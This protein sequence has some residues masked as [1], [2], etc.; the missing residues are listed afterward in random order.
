MIG[1]VDGGG[2]AVTDRL[3]APGPVDIDVIMASVEALGSPIKVIVRRL[4]PSLEAVVHQ[5]Q[6]HT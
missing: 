1:A 6:I 3:R 2:I 5:P 4:L